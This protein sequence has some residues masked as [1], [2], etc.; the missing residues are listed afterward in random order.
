MADLNKLPAWSPPKDTAQAAASIS[1]LGRNMHEHAYLVGRILIWVKG[2]V[3]NRK[4]LPWLKANVWFGKTTAFQMMKFANICLKAGAISEYHTYHTVTRSIGSPGELIAEPTDDDEAERD[5]E[6]EPDV[7]KQL[8][9]APWAQ[10]LSDLSAATKKTSV[11]DIVNKNIKS[12]KK[13]GW[14]YDE[15]SIEDLERIQRWL[16]ELIEGLRPLIVTCA[17]KEE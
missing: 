12:F 4:F 11:T 1:H 10:A 13:T 6:P 7:Y 9:V 5:A 2:K 8:K 16:S 17:T 14:G 3:G 15:S